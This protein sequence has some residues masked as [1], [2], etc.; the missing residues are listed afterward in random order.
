MPDD[1]A[2]ERGFDDGRRAGFLEG[3]AAGYFE[4]HRAGWEQGVRDAGAGSRVAPPVQAEPP[5]QPPPPPAM[6]P[7]VQALPRPE[8]GRGSG[9][10]PSRHAV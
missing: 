8:F 3:H 4:G 10:P 2:Y 1:P 9:L 5:I 6:A 7:S